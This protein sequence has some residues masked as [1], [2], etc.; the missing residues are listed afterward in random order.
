MSA[1]DIYVVYLDAIVGGK[2]PR[3]RD[4]APTIIAHRIGE[5][6]RA[7][8]LSPADRL[9]VETRVAV[10]DG[11]ARGYGTDAAAAWLKANPHPETLGAWEWSHWLANAVQALGA[12]PAVKS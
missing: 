5:L 3:V 10:L 12:A 1:T 7:N 8:G 9:T 6:A 11:T 2:E 4:G